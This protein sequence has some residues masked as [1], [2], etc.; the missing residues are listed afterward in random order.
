M[1]PKVKIEVT[2]GGEGTEVT[3]GQGSKASDYIP[4]I[5][6]DNYTKREAE[7]EAAAQSEFK[8]T[9]IVVA[10][11]TKQVVNHLE[12]L[13]TYKKGI[14][15]KLK[16]DLGITTEKPE[17][18]KK[19][20]SIVLG[21]GAGDEEPEDENKQAIKDQINEMKRDPA[22][23]TPKLDFKSKINFITQAKDYYEAIKSFNNALLGIG[24]PEEMG[25]L[26]GQVGGDLKKDYQN[27]LVQFDRVKYDKAEALT[28]A[29]FFSAVGGMFQSAAAGKGTVATAGPNALAAGIA[30][31]QAR[32]DLIDNANMQL[33]Q[34]NA[35][36]ARE[37]YTKA[38]E[39]ATNYNIAYNQNEK[40]KNDYAVSVM[41]QKADAWS[42][43]IDKAGVNYRSLMG[44][45]GKQEE[46][47]RSAAVDLMKA[48]ADTDIE[49]ARLKY[50]KTKW[51]AD[52]LAKQSEVK[53][54]VSKN[55]ITPSEYTNAQAI[56]KQFGVEPSA[57]MNIN[58]SKMSE[59]DAAKHNQ[60][61]GRVIDDQVKTIVA[62]LEEVFNDGIINFSRD[63]DTKGALNFISSM[64]NQGWLFD[65]ESLRKI[66]N[67]Y[68]SGKDIPVNTD[69]IT[70][71][72]ITD[73]K[74]VK[75]L[76]VDNRIVGS[77]KK[78]GTMSPD[79]ARE[80][81]SY[82]MKVRQDNAEIN[83]NGQVVVKNAA[84]EAE[85][86]RRMESLA[87]SMGIQ[88]ANKQR[89]SKKDGFTNGAYITLGVLN[90]V[91]NLTESYVGINPVKSIET[92]L[93]FTRESAEF[94]PVNLSGETPAEK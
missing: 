68:K 56:A 78:K 47:E 37:Y 80:L 55:L 76:I 16:S 4:A 71:K 9:S 53:E 49:R 24:S 36:L 18:K 21:G 2:A 67:Y 70:G 35:A 51:T 81:M 74:L 8:P 52:Y 26:R 43:A 5:N 39:W 42:D 69:I 22:I 44:L 89:I 11:A 79:E 93:P 13:G 17:D 87:Q 65:Q 50:E 66:G 45:A 41:K 57:I 75:D 40:L 32:Q 64:V 25:K 27:S 54:A 3:K 91:K 63:T 82:Y 15:D 19:E 58:F 30:D 38:D 62:T 85:V 23:G 72:I 59:A 28:R 88:R 77:I 7:I 60:Q 1:A 31:I 33:D 73:D 34:K 14:L 92:G 29:M 83:R 10:E 86:E 6:L 46:G 48:K 61:Y 90:Q 12:S 94:N 20:E 84:L